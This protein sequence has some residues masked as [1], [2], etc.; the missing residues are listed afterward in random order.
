MTYSLDL[1]KRVVSFVESGGTRA[2]ASRRFD[3]HYDTVRN[4]LRRED[5]RPKTHGP[6]RRKLDKAALKQHVR[7]HPDARLVDRAT[8]FG[9]HINAI[10]VALRTMNIVKKSA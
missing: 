5:L 3:V 2:E 6:R 8:H 9:V 4:W 10:W 7:E 1:R